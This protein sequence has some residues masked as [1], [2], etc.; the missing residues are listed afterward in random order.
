MTS[1]DP[2][3][4]GAISLDQ[5]IALNDEIAALARAGVPLEPALAELGSD[6]PGR[7]GAIAATFAE[8]TRRGESLLEILSD[9]S[10]QLPPVYRAVVEAGLRTGRLPAALEA[11]AG[12][13]RRVAETRRGVAAAAFYPLLVLVLAWGFF[14]FFAVGIAPACLP[15]CRMAPM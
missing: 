14:A 7:L 9:Q 6:M 8:R 4:P 2:S 15:D 13:I 5:L 10:L 1:S 11:L 3:N 12:S